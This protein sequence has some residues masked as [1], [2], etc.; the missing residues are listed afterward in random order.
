[1]K[2]I[3][4]TGLVAATH[5]PF[6]ADG[7]LN[8]DVV[9]QQ[10]KQ[11]IQDDVGTAFISGSTGESHSLT[12]EER[13]QMTKRWMEVTRGTNLRVV[14][15]VGSNCLADA[16]TLAAQANDLGAHAI[17]AL[18]PSYFKPRNL[19]GLIDW[20][21]EIAMAAP[22]TPFYFYDIPSMTGVTLS[23][24]DFLAQAPARIPT[25]RGIKFSNSD[26]VSYQLCL[27]AGAGAFDIPFGI[28][29]S[30]L[31]SLALGAKGAVGSSY[32]FAAPLYHRLWRA[33]TA[34]DLVTAR[35]EQLH[36]VQLIQLLANI[37][38]FGA[39]KAVMK[40]RGV[41]VGPARLPHNNPTEE[42]VT[43][44]RGDLE[45]LGFF[46]WVGQKA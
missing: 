8:L 24:P 18:A 34:G 35:K 12:L 45:R 3:E 33:F 23:M 27:A 6:G 41:D 32:N 30:L 28:D 29:E 1:M 26:L 31:G 42:Q 46:E 37:G 22:A 38:Y 25:L 10:A 14:V 17:A 9:E 16:R 40:M 2:S 19:A 11:L 36:S 21:A 20:C 44:L 43:K 15:H 39:A 13:R 7:A 5:T 4:L